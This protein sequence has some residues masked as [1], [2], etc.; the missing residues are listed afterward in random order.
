MS[1]SDTSTIRPTFSRS[2]LNSEAKRN[3]KLYSSDDMHEKI[4]NFWATPP[5]TGKSYPPLKPLKG[6]TGEIYQA[7]EKK[8]ELELLKI[9]SNLCEWVA[10]EDWEPI[11][12]NMDL[13]AN[14]AKPI[15]RGLLGSKRE[16]WKGLYRYAHLVN[17]FLIAVETLLEQDSGQVLQ[18]IF[19]RNGSLSNHFENFLHVGHPVLRLLGTNFGD[20]LHFYLKKEGQILDKTFS[21]YA[22]QKPSGRVLEMMDHL[23][24]ALKSISTELFDIYQLQRAI[25]EKDQKK[26]VDTLPRLHQKHLKWL[27]QLPNVRKILF[28]EVANSLIPLINSNSDNIC[29]WAFYFP[30][31]QLERAIKERLQEFEPVQFFR[32]SLFIENL[33]ELT[34]LHFVKIADCKNPIIHQLMGF[35]PDYLETGQIKTYLKSIS[36]QNLQIFM[37]SLHPKNFHIVFEE[38]SRRHFDYYKTTIHKTFYPRKFYLSE[39]MIQELDNELK[40]DASKID[41]ILNGWIYPGL[42]ELD[43][44]LSNLKSLKPVTQKNFEI[45]I[46]NLKAKK[47][48]YKDFIELFETKA[49]HSTEGIILCGITK[50]PVVFPV[51]LPLGNG[52]YS[53]VFD[54]ECLMQYRP[55]FGVETSQKYSFFHLHYDGNVDFEIRN[56]QK[57][58]FS[59]PK[60]AQRPVEQ[61]SVDD[62]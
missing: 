51:R 19:T 4:K 6:R 28:S 23:G 18:D 27:Y 47:V 60:A 30:K 37:D 50:E 54:K 1:I 17:P 12:R 24:S 38:F 57:K 2:N 61:E 39:S 11:L 26:I 40:K 35:I 36:M 14:F 7:K 46:A 34:P 15:F 21:M 44:W 3:D 43:T 9:Q 42:K 13:I 5:E 29:E 10:Q 32:N 53:A 48:S 62:E 16:F 58:L 45:L 49:T 55:L 41:P 59:S 31:P 52:R 56:F 25:L 20:K 33:N 22:C 8:K